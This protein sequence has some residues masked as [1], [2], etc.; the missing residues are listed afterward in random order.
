ML[1]RK[2]MRMWIGVSVCL[3][4]LIAASVSDG[5]AERPGVLVIGD[6][7]ATGM[8]WHQEGIAVM[9]K[10]LD[11]L[12]SVDV[13]RTIGGISCP[14]RGKRPPTLLQVVA[15]RGAVPPTVIVVVG[16]NDPEDAFADEVDDAMSALVAAGARNVLWFTLRESQSQY[17]AMNT[18]LAEAQMRWPQL[19]LVDWNAASRGQNSWFQSDNEH[20]TLT[21]G[22]ALA[23]L[24]HG[25]VTEIL[26][27]LHVRAPLWLQAG[28]SYAVRLRADGGT[29][30]YRWRVVSGSPPRGFRLLANG[31]LTT[32]ARPGTKAS[33]VLSVTDADGTTA[34]LPV[35]ER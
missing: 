22:L 8:Y 13:C 19:V 12:W 30:P 10:N 5:A 24:A 18:L 23:H 29:P 11:V 4:A 1:R 27:P 17:A 2:T 28:R 3:A 33:L 7:V 6:S 9:Q 34:E 21:G 35:I 26:N 14:W 20:L 16:Y 25:A 32:V 31:S 15:A